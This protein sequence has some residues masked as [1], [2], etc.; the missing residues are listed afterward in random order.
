MAS[1][2]NQDYLK[3]IY[4]FNEKGLSA[5]TS[6]IASSIGISPP[7]VTEMLKRLEEGGYVIYKPYKGALLTEKGRSEAERVVRK[8]RLLERF[9]TDILGLNKQRVHDQACELEHSLS[10]EAEDAL[11]RVLNYPDTCPDDG[12]L[13][14]PCSKEVSSCLECMDMTERRRVRRGRDLVPLTALNVGE[15]GIIAFIRGGRAAVQRLMDMGLTRGTRVRI[16]ASAPFNGPLQLM[17][18]GAT[19]AIGRGL[20]N[21][22]FVKAALP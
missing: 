20:A 4:N 14:P 12:K 2:S 9:L 19:L 11:C 18:R 5:R 21:R 6:D 1:R 22:I 16:L 10:D 7:S 15:E 8:H 13:I 17:V 3:A